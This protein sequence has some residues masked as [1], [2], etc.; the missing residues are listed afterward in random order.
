MI[1]M[2]SI[3]GTPVSAQDIAYPRHSPLLVQFKTPG[4]QDNPVSLPFGTI[5]P[6]LEIGQSEVTAKLPDGAQVLIRSADV[7][8]P[9]S[10]AFVRHGA[11]MSSQDR[12]RLSFWDSALRAKG[13]LRH[14]PTELTRP[15]LQEA[16]IG[17]MPEILPVLDITDVTGHSERSIRLIN[18]LIPMSI[19]TLAFSDADSV[20]AS[21]PVILHILVDGSEYTREFSQ[22][23]LRDLSRMLDAQIVDPTAPVQVQQSVLFNNGE[24]IELEAASLSSLRRLLPQPPGVVDGTLSSA[25]LAAMQRVHDNIA[26]DELAE[27][28]HIVLVLLGPGLNAGLVDDPDLA[29]LAQE[30]ARLAT[31]SGNIGLLLGSV[32]P[33]PSEMPARILNGLGRG[34]P[35]RLVNFGA[36]LDAEVVNMLGDLT[37]PLG[38]AN[39]DA[40]CTQAR[41]YGFPC[42]SGV[43]VESWQQLLPD[44]RDAAAMEWFSLP[45][46]FVADDN[47]LV[48]ETLPSVFSDNHLAG[49]QEMAALKSELFRE[50]T[51]GMQLT[52]Q[53]ERASADR[54][55]LQHELDRTE[56]ILAETRLEARRHKE[57]AQVALSG[58]ENRISLLQQELIET[59]R[60]AQELERLLRDSDVELEQGRRALELALAGST[61]MREAL[62]AERSQ[63]SIL[64]HELSERELSEQALQ[65]NLAELGAIKAAQQDRMSSLEQNLA[66]EK[67]LRREVE[68]ERNALFEQITMRDTALASLQIKLDRLVSERDEFEALNVSLES[69]LRVAETELQRSEQDSA[70]LAMQIAQQQSYF[71][72]Q[73]NTLEADLADASA[74]LKKTRAQL[75]DRETLITNLQAQEKLNQDEKDNL[76]FELKTLRESAEKLNLSL[77]E[78]DAQLQLTVMELDQ[79]RTQEQQLMAEIAGFSRLISEK[80]SE[81]LSVREALTKSEEQGRATAALV[82]TLQSQA[83]MQAI[84]SQHHEMQS[85]DGRLTFSDTA[86]QERFG[87]LIASQAPA[88]RQTRMSL[89]AL[90]LQTQTI[91]EFDPILILPALESAIQSAL[92]AEFQIGALITQKDEDYAQLLKTVVS[93]DNLHSEHISERQELQLAYDA[94]ISRLQTALA[95][96]QDMFAEIL[97]QELEELHA[98]YAFRLDNMYLEHSAELDSLRAQYDEKTQ[99]I[100][101][102]LFDLA[103]ALSV[104]T[105]QIP[106]WSSELELLRELIS[107]AEIKLSDLQARA[108]FA[109]ELQ[110]QT[111]EILVRRDEV[112]SDL[113]VRLT[114]SETELE[115]LRE[116]M[117]LAIGV[118]NENMQL[119]AY[120]QDM[121]RQ[122]STQNDAHRTEV[123]ELRRQLVEATGRDGNSTYETTMVETVRI[124]SGLRPQ[125]RPETLTVVSQIPA[126]AVSRSPAATSEREPKRQ[127]GAT[128]A[129]EPSTLPGSPLMWS[130]VPSNPTT[131]QGGFFG[132]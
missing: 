24:I 3:R 51:M 110:G 85:L 15:F 107:R 84:G 89:E 60:D 14:G 2:C 13:F 11:G 55:R 113:T 59:T 33:E 53:L 129:P 23:Q 22:R 66:Q 56:N 39:V 19:D 50:K 88:L 34:F 80:E 62:E 78:I 27:K 98:I 4:G 131:S 109:E 115:F 1:C 112:V 12:A 119:L 123:T 57:Q 64:A 126:S 82:N 7:Y 116:Q 58:A 87:Q 117:Q 47:L 128:A 105:A 31:R 79:S 28:T 121:E 130:T 6:L 32:T 132:N 95:A 94:E 74:V 120:L 102:L 37:Q 86:A 106:Q 67:H 41:D 69:K 92:T 71:D 73:R 100:T 111:S 9:P 125:A 72:T 96:Q 68:A 93:P 35:S 103:T 91:G 18:G 127:S 36:A 97:S 101:L 20:A 54:E 44:A 76:S 40:L 63:V 90:S 43:G 16:G 42:L 26:A 114:D 83:L 104:D 77:V 108:I 30:L 75:L 10:P 122:L 65:R 38:G 5:L 70:R 8:I 21:R 46:W 81:L 48:L 52:E 45:M 29:S 61:A 118:A 124:P 99:T 17:G 25:V 49:S